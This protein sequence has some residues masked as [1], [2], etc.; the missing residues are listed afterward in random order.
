MASAVVVSKSMVT[1]VAAD[2]FEVV[3]SSAD[4]VEV[5]ASPANVVDE[6]ASP[7][8]EIASSVDDGVPGVPGVV[9][10]GGPLL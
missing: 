6:V 2:V 1:D 7:E 5:V 8:V 9:V 3:V 10:A 4:E